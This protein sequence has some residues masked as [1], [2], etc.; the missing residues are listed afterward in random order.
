MPGIAELQNLSA[1]HGLPIG[2]LLVCCGC[3]VL[4]VR[5]LYKEN[6]RIHRQFEQLVEERT[7]TLDAVLFQVLSSKRP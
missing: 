2:V 7:K 6:Q 1:T 3:L 5:T 4:A